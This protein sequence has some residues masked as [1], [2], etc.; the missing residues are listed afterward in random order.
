MYGDPIVQVGE[1]SPVGVSGLDRGTE[2]GQP[3]PLQLRPLVGVLGKQPCGTGRTFADESEPGPAV[4]GD[5]VCQPRCVIPINVAGMLDLGIGG[6]ATFKRERTRLLIYFGAMH[7]L[8]GEVGAHRY[9]GHGA[10]VAR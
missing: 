9:V 10:V 2:Q 6:R 7:K 3:M 5:D 1:V 4:L 8:G